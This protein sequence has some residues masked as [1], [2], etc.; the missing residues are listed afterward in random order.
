MV[1]RSFYRVADEKRRSVLEC[2]AQIHSTCGGCV[3][4]SWIV[5]WF[6]TV[7]FMPRNGGPN[8]C[9]V[10]LSLLA[11]TGCLSHRAFHPARWLTPVVVVAVL[12]SVGVAADDVWRSEPPAPTAKC[13]KLEPKEFVV[14][15]HVAS[16][17]VGASLLKPAASHEA[18]D[19]T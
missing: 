1:T 19:M 10:M 7:Q 3:V 8:S 9:G 16:S 12:S 6:L 5:E 18:E 11:G 4:R 15:S 14:C 13:V 2:S 17:R